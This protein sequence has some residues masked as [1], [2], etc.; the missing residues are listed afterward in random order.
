[1]TPRAVAAW[2]AFY[3]GWLLLAPGGER[4]L[5]LQPPPQR[6]RSIPSWEWLR[7]HVD[8]ARSREAGGTVAGPG[9]DGLLRVNDELTL[10]IVIDLHRSGPELES[11]RLVVSGGSV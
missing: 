2:L 1:M 3:A 8:P 6:L 4:G 7:L 10:S 5:W 9:P 11:L